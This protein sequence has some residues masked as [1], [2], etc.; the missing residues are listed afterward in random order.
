MI[1][2]NNNEED[3]NF[4]R[5]M[6][7]FFDKIASIDSCY[8]NGY[9]LITNKRTLAELTEEKLV[10]V[11]PFNPK[12]RES[13]LKVA[14]LMISYFASIEEYEKCAELVKVK[15]EIENTNSN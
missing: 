6:D 11:F 1:N 15:K 3:D 4:E 2:Y 14:D 13:F 7:E 12:Q 8:N 5:E 9:K 10:V